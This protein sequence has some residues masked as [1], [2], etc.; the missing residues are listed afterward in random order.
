MPPKPK[1]QAFSYKKN[2]N[3]NVR[4]TMNYEHGVTSTFLLTIKYWELFFEYGLG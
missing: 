1:P 4:S 3:F 2:I